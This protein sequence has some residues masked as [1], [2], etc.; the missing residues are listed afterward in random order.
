MIEPGVLP[1]IGRYRA[2]R[3]EHAVAS[4]E[5]Y[6][7]I[8]IVVAMLWVGAA[9]L[10]VLLATHAVVSRDPA[11]LA[12][13]VDA[14]GWLGLLL[15]L[16]T[17]LIVF[18]SA[19][20]LVHEGDWSYDPLWIWF[21]IVGFVASFLAGALFLG[22]AWGRVG[23]MTVRGDFSAAPLQTGIRQLVLAGWLD[24]GWVLAV[25]F[26]MLVKPASSEWALGVTAAIPAMSALVALALVRMPAR[27]PTRS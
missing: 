19:V 23:Q 25:V 8:H 27:A 12:A 20:L 1:S 6:L 16:P 26:L 21:G 3:R 17:N 9:F 14:G 11:R 7:L 18:G 24:A 5:L 15:F 2:N 10:I 22:P 13:L 4:Y